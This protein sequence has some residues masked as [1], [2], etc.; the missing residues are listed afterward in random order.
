MRARMTGLFGIFVAVLMLMGG[1]AVERRETRREERRTKE[2]LAVAVERARDEVTEEENKDKTLLQTAIS[3]QG[4]LAAGGLVLVVADSHGILW[5]SRQHAPDWPA[6][7]DDW[8]FQTLTHGDQTLVMAREWEPVEAAL[9]ETAFA[10]LQ[11]GL[12]VVCATA[13]AAWFV[14]GKTL[15]P[16][17]RLAAQAQNSSTDLMHVRLQSPSS[18]AEMRHLTATLNELLSRLAKEAQARGRFYAA[19]SHELRTPIQVLLG[20][21]DVALSRPRSVEEHETTLVEV[22]DHAERLARL[23]QDLLQLN[24]LEMRQSVAACE[25]LNLVFWLE[26]ALEQQAGLIAERGLSLDT[27]FEDG[28]ITAPPAHVEILLR[29]LLENAAK[30]AAPGSALRISLSHY[31][32]AVT[33]SIW[34]ACDMA[35][36]ADLTLWFEPFF[37]PDAARNS[38]TG[39]N[40]LGLSIVAALARSNDWKVELKTQDGGVLAQVRFPDVVKRSEK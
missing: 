19:A 37:R 16:L 14:V 29:N 36:N 18:D 3:G 21:I 33:L 28:M 20:R 25:E 5:R 24:S 12:I 6:V 11:L 27:K 8:R 13:L 31:A 35:P 22:Q 1:A 30:Y 32:Q 23:V 39:G 10:L 26:R 7:S 17:E 4:E 15:S 9:R 38:Q 40:G 34:N 2:I